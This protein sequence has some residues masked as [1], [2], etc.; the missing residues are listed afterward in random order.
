MKKF[1][2]IFFTLGIVFLSLMGK[3]FGQCSILNYN[4]F[5]QDSLKLCGNSSVI[6]NAGS[7][8]DTYSWSTGSITDTIIVTA[9]RSGWYY[10]TVTDVNGCIGLDSVFVNIV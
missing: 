3:A 7:G 8:Y 5:P 6:L 10:I 4:P 2:K 9:G 1:I